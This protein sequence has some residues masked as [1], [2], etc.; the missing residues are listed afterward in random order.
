MYTCLRAMM[1]TASRL[2]RSK[3]KGREGAK[4]KS[5]EAEASN[6]IKHSIGFMMSLSMFTFRPRKKKLVQA[7]MAV[8]L[9]KEGVSPKC[10]QL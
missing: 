3:V 4:R 1:P 9:G 5:T 6:M 10:L 2:H 8:E 7:C